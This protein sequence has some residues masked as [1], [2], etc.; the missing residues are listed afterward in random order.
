MKTLFI[1]GLL[2]LSIASAEELH[3]LSDI[4]EDKEINGLESFTKGAGAILSIAQKAIDILKSSKTSEIKARIE[5]KG[6]DYFKGG[7]TIR[8]TN[9]VRIE[10]L[11]GY[12]DNLF[13]R[14]KVPQDQ[15]PD[16]KDRML[17]IQYTDSGIA[18]KTYDLIFNAGSSSN[19]NCH[20][21][22]FVGAYNSQGNLDV[23]YSFMKSEFKL[24]P[25]VTI[26]TSSRS[27]VGGVWSDI[28]DEIKKT[29]H[30]IKQEDITYIIAFFELIGLEQFSQFLGVKIPTLK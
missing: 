8:K 27:F 5:G 18:F 19:E 21:L 3:F 28:K 20:A 23:F 25:D 26:M 13:K 11:E 6:F 12:L 4:E 1:L 7:C 9:G 14:I 17:D 30:Q 2:L 16:I 29:P 10:Q 24:A 15:I 22:S